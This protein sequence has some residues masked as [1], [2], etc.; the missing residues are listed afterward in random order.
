VGP[1]DDRV[2][3]LRVE[4][5]QTVRAIEVNLEHLTLGRAS[6][7]T[8][9][10]PDTSVGRFHAS[11]EREGATL[12]LT[13][14]GR[15]GGTWI[16]GRPVETESATVRV[17][18]RITLGKTHVTLE[19]IL[20]GR[21]VAAA[22]PAPAPLP[23]LPPDT[24]LAR[25][26]EDS[27]FDRLKSL[28]RS[29][30]AAPAPA[31]VVLPPDLPVADI[32]DP[33]VG[34]DTE[35]LRAPGS[36][37]AEEARA[38]RRILEIN[39]RL[40]R[41]TEED[42][43]LDLL[44]DA[45]ADLT[46]AD[47]GL[48]LLRG[49]AEG[50]LRVRRDHGGA[51]ADR[52]QWTSA[53]KRVLATG[54]T[55]RLG[56]DGAD[57]RGLLCVPL[58]G[59]RAVLGLLYLDRL[60]SAGPFDDRA[61][62]LLEA[63]ADQASL[64]LQT[65]ALVRENRRR[66]EELEAA[67][68]RLAEANGKLEE[69]LRDRTRELHTARE[70]AARARSDLQ[71][72]YRY[73]RIVGR[74]A[75]MRT[76]LTLVDKVVDSTVPVLVEGESGTGKELVARAIHF[77]GARAGKPFVVENCAAVP[78]ALIESELF[79]HE[80]GSFTGADRTTEGLFERGDGG[81]VFLDEVGDMSPDM[82]KKLL[83]VLQEGE[84]RRVGGKETRRVDVRVVSATNRDLARMVKEGTFRED[85][86][87]RLCVVRVRMPPLRERREDVPLLA[88]RFLD[89]IAEESAGGAPRIDASALDALTSY[90]WPGNVRELENEVRRA[91]TLSEGV[92]TREVLSPH[93]REALAGPAAGARSHPGGGGGGWGAGDPGRTLREAV[94]DLERVMLLEIL[95]EH[96][97]NKTRAARALGLSRLGLRKKM[98]RYGMDG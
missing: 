18:D 92:I 67:G 14:S 63:F 93:V 24:A 12:R 54:R 52:E 91:A 15:G 85:L 41:V 53:A 17:G 38:L 80:K 10:L 36:T 13:P 64:A 25:P 68:T 45:A 69:A 56:G 34:F 78:E 76:L 2:I 20:P 48:V 19:A 51:A 22:A 79:G 50:S 83:R 9:H 62:L 5:Q 59:D 57:H 88:I 46:G 47:R 72:K 27:L 7:C 21:T 97:G 95:K 94:E 77:N 86:F 96:A 60:P 23:P 81:T 40:A 26:K 1:G 16:N 32:P 11:L 73:D 43:L 90:G 65:A 35:T 42:R 61:A 89:R 84:V 30:A 74:S 98:G 70:E 58:K 29:T 75:P 87:Y 66:S 37:G 8:V 31:P 3:R 44:L 28:G 49:E 6:G 33:T 82:Q 55:V 39:K 71:L 4:D